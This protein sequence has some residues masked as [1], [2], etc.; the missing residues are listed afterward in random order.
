MHLYPTTYYADPADLPAP[1]PSIAEINGCEEAVGESCLATVVGIGPYVTKYGEDVKVVECETLLFLQGT[2]IPV[3]R[4]YA[5]F[6][7]PETK[8]NYVIMGRIFGKTLGELWPTMNDSA[9]GG[10]TSRLRCIF[11]DMR[12]LEYPGGYCSAGGRWLP[13]FSEEVELP[14]APPSEG[15]WTRA[16]PRFSSDHSIPKSSSARR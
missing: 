4:V 11:D 2:T 9:K 15:S 7:D 3:P 8:W 6:Q 13:F 5:I 1:L 12:K 10:V 16:C 14:L